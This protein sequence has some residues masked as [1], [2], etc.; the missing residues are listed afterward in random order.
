MDYIK[1]IESI[2]KYIEENLEEELRL[3]ELAQKCYLSK[4]YFHRIFSA[5]MG[6]SLKEYIN[7]RRLNKALSY[8]LDTSKSIVEI[9]YKLQFGSQASFTRAFKNKFGFPPGRVRKESEGLKPS[10]IPLVVRRVMKNF[11]SD[12]VTDFTFVEKEREVLTG[13]YM[14]VDLLDEDIQYKVNSKAENLLKS[15]KSSEAYN[16]FA[17]YFYDEDKKKKS[18]IPTFFGIDLESK[19]Q[20]LNWQTYEIPSMLYAKFR[21]V[22]DL[23]Y[24]GDT[25]VTDLKRW[26]KI[27]KIEMIETEISFIQAYDK[28]YDENGLFNIYLPIGEIPQEM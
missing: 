3:E 18:C 19:N 20:N 12:V 5:V 17:V 1:M 24:I 4:Y 10:P 6:C 27:S 13:F 8:V 21:Y 9:A 14:D 7:Q 16:A 23:L 28:E 11:N 15:I 25:V 22:G 2:I 26:M